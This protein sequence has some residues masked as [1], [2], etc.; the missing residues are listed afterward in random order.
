MLYY[1]NDFNQTISS[2]LWKLVDVGQPV[3][4]IF[5]VGAQMV[6]SQLPFGELVS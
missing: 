3:W 4:T 5:N 6:N 1:T 2:K